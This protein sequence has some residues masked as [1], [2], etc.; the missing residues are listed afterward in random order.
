MIKLRLS[1]TPFLYL[2]TI[3]HISLHSTFPSMFTKYKYSVLPHRK[4]VKNIYEQL[5]REALIINFSKELTR[6]KD[7]KSISSSMF[8]YDSPKI[9]LISSSL[10]KSSKVF[11]FLKT[12]GKSLTVTRPDWLF[13]DTNY[14]EHNKSCQPKISM[15]PCNYWH[16]LSQDKLVG[17]KKKPLTFDLRVR[18]WTWVNWLWS[19]W[20]ETRT[21]TKLDIF[22]LVGAKYQTLQ[23]TLIHNTQLNFRWIRMESS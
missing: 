12:G 17:R 19:H 14:K 8:S 22:N 15:L 18:S 2:S 4:D 13:T 9:R 23:G 5:R 7:S 3:W 10:N 11:N 20:S 1:L 16:K 6:R 21:P